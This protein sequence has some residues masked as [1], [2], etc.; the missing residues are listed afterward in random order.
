M[1]GSNRSVD[2][3]WFVNI[4]SINWILLIGNNRYIN[5]LLLIESINQ[6]LLVGNY[7]SINWQLSITNQL[8]SI[9]NHRLI[10][11]IL[12][13]WL[14]TI[15]RLFNYSTIWLTN[16]ITYNFQNL[17]ISL[18]KLLID[19]MILVLITGCLTTLKLYWILQTHILINWHNLLIDRMVCQPLW[20]VDLSIVWIH[21]DLLYNFYWSTW[22]E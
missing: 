21:F 11:R 6:V 13:T 3:S 7:R 14:V 17:L 20:S 5:W 15:D 1:I 19:R 8:L 18:W 16:H 4:W 9:S 2:Y 10:N 22:F 12:L